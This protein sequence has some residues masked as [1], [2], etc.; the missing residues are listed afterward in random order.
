MKVELRL[1]TVTPLFLGGAEQ[2]PELRPASL[3]G[4]LRYWFRAMLGG[5]IGDDDD[6]LKELRRREAE[7]FGETE[8][9]S[10]VV[11]R[12]RGMLREMASFDLDR[13]QQGRQTPSGHNY[14]YYSTR[15][16][17]NRRVPFG[18]N[19]SNVVLTLTARSGVGNAQGALQKA[20]AAAWLLTHLG[21]IGMRSRR[22]GGSVQVVEGSFRDLPEFVVS[23]QS[24]QDLQ[25]HLQTGL[26]WP[27]F[28]RFWRYRQG[29]SHKTG[30][31]ILLITRCL[32]IGRRK[33]APRL[34]KGWGEMDSET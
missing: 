15:L 19:Q 27:K 1:E 22:C 17:Q 23:G 20:A 30:G 16:G 11:V 3:R 34:E 9:G 21:G 7:V 4:A 18:A 33:A 8:R 6:A 13:D 26:N 14:L 31:E 28:Q 2:Q 12:L 25:Q 32:R 5:V 29:I 10:G 24:P